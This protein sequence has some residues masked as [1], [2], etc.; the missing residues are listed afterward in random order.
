MLMTLLHIVLI[1]LLVVLGLT[2]AIGLLIAF[3]PF[4]IAIRRRLE[5]PP[6]RIRLS[7]GPLHITRRFGKKKAAAS[8]E[9]KPGKKKR[10]R[11]KKKKAG[12]DETRKGM[13]S[14]FDFSQLKWEDTLDLAL[15]LMDD[16]MGTITFEKLH[17]TVILHTGDAATTGNLLGALCAATGMLYPELERRFVL[18]DPKITL[19]ADFDAE[20]T[21]WSVD[22]S[23]MTRAARYPWILWKR[24]KRLWSLWKTIRRHEVGKI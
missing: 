14:R 11:R 9:A 24:R 12:Q 2:V 21:V 5:G 20:K 3:V 17:V 23:M 15:Q 18:N 10:R 4:R 8:E 13:R 6:L 1:L 19:D 22:I 7:V 16:L